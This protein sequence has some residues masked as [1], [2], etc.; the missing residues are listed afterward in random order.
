MQ[1]HNHVG[2]WREVSGIV[3]VVSWIALVAMIILATTGI[4]QFSANWLVAELTIFVIA[5]FASVFRERRHGL[6]PEE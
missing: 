3:A 4:F 5:V 1:R 6:P 2:W